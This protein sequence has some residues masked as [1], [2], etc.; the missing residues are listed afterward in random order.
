MFANSVRKQ[1]QVL[2]ERA[3]AQYRLMLLDGQIFV[4]R[5]D[6]GA[7]AARVGRDVSLSSCH[8]SSF[9]ILALVAW[10]RSLSY[11]EDDRHMY[12]GI[13]SQIDAQV[14]LSVCRKSSPSSPP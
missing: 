5:G 11:L 4:R 9:L 3:A 10:R 8:D 13:L 14:R 7:L 1:P 6:M 12:P 2:A